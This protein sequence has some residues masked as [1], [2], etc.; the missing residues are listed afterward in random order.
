MSNPVFRTDRMY[1]GIDKAVEKTVRE[2]AK[3]SRQR[4][5]VRTRA[6]K[7]SIS[8]RERFATR[9]RGAGGRSGYLGGRIISTRSMIANWYGRFVDEGTK[10]APAKRW[11]PD[12]DDTA[13]KAV[14]NV[15]D[16][17]IKHI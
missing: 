6:L 12:I 7:R 4:V 10:R 14:E 15:A 8:V 2:A 13:R 16:A 1:A 3:E 5:P 11:T 17:I 9:Q